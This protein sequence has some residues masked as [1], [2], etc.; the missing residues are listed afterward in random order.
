MKQRFIF[1]IIILTL[2][3][4]PL[5]ANDAL[6]VNEKIMIEEQRNHTMDRDPSPSYQQTAIP[7]DEIFD[8]IDHFPVGVGGG[9]YSVTTDGDH[10]YTAAWNSTGFYRYETDGTYIGEFTIAGAGNLR[11]LT[12]DGEYFYGSPNSNTI[13]ELDLDGESLIGSFT[14][15]ASSSVRGIA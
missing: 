15:T 4:L 12:Y 2:L 3:S 6:S 10:I 9:E 11:D 7:S 5:L 1:S 13:Y 8:L 14:T